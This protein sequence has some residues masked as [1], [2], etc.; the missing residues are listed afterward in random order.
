MQ[1]HKSDNP[2]VYRLNCSDPADRWTVEVLGLDHMVWWPYMD[3]KIRVSSRVCP[4]EWPVTGL[5]LSHKR[6]A[7]TC[8]STPRIHIHIPAWFDPRA[9]CTRINKTM[10]LSLMRQRLP[11]EAK[12]NSLCPSWPCPW[13]MTVRGSFYTLVSATL[14]WR[15]I[16]D[17]LVRARWQRLCWTPCRRKQERWCC[18]FWREQLV[19]PGLGFGG[20]RCPSCFHTV[21]QLALLRASQESWEKVCGR[22]RKST[23]TDDMVSPHIGTG[24]LL[25]ILSQKCFSILSILPIR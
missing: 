8:V 1:S 19:H 22:L 17:F 2:L 13:V 4:W 24:Q 7:G 23:V 11:A 14:W 18:C 16:T 9:T 5:N 3:T 21:L 12:V 10:M 6:P 20:A 25:Q 15:K